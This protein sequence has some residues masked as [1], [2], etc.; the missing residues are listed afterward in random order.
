[1]R[2][3]LRAAVTPLLAGCVLLG[4]RINRHEQSIAASVAN[5]EAAGKTKAEWRQWAQRALNVMACAAITPERDCVASMTSVPPTATASPHRGRIFHAWPEEAKTDALQWAFEQLMRGLDSV[6][7]HWPACVRSIHIQA[8]FETARIQSAWRDAAF[9]LRRTPAVPVQ[10]DES[11]WER[12]FDEPDAAPRLFV[13]VQTW[14]ASREP[15]QFSEL[16]VALL[17]SG[18]DAK[19]AT[20]IPAAWIGRPMSTSGE[21]L[22]TD[23]AMLFEYS[24]IDSST[25]GSA[26]LT[27]VPSDFHGTLTQAMSRSNDSGD[28]SAYRID[29]YLGPAHIVQYWFALAAAAKSQ[30]SGRPQLTVA[31]AAKGWVVHLVTGSQATHQLIA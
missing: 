1:M 2:F 23:L 28:F 9:A 29:H 22:H 20:A 4:L 11:D 19:G 31:E 13:G 5:E 27:G 30:G 15:Q 7:P 21:T 24:E 18:R 12:M 16:A 3:W 26:W 14:P 17:V 25:V 6:L 10:F 8:E